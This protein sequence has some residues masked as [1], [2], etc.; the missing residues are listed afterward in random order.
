MLSSLSE[1]LEEE[2]EEDSA[3]GAALGATTTLDFFRAGDAGASDGFFA[4]TFAAAL[5][6]EDSFGWE[7]A[8]ER[9]RWLLVL[10]G[11]TVVVEFFECDDDDV[12]DDEAVVGDGVTMERSRA[13]PCREDIVGGAGGRDCAVLVAAEEDGAA[14]PTTFRFRSV[15]RGASG[16]SRSAS[17]FFAAARTT[18]RSREGG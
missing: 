17:S 14:S 7:F 4:V 5:E 9:L 1:P 12:V 18:R 6:S 10:R 11:S 15:R 2:D 8:A 3:T 16:V 13:E